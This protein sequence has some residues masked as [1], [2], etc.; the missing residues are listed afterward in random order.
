MKKY[1]V[2]ITILALLNLLG[3]Y[4][5]QTIS[6]EEIN[7]GE[8]CGDLQVFTKN[9]YIYEFDKGNYTINEDSI[10]GSGNLKLIM[11]KKVFQHYEGSISFVDIEKLRTDKLDVVTTILVIAIP[12]AVIVIA[13]SNFKPLGNGPI[14][15]K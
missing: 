10:Y 3:C 7:Q 5:Y 9:K 6:R 12:V 14:F 8:E 2:T 11:G 4:S 15:S 13:G 1:I